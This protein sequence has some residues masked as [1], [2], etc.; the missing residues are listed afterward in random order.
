MKHFPCICCKQS[1]KNNQKALLCT[2]CNEWIHISCAGIPKR[3]Y[4][5]DTEHFVNWQCRKCLFRILPFYTSEN[6]QCKSSITKK[7]SSSK[8]KPDNIDLP[9]KCNITGKGLKFAHLNVVSL[10]K[11][12]EEIKLFLEVNDIDILALNETRLDETVFDSEITIPLYKL[13]RK[14]RNKQGGGVAIYF[15]NSLDVQTIAHESLCHL[16]ANCIKIFMKGSRPILFLNWYRPPNSKADIWDYYEHFLEFADSLN[17]NIVIMGDLNVDILNVNHNVLNHKYLALNSIYSLNQINMTEPTRI[18]HECATLLD[19]MITNDLSN[20]QSHGIVHVGMSDHS[21]SY[22]VWKFTRQ[23]ERSRTTQYRNL[24]KFVKEEFKKDLRSQPWHTVVNCSNLDEAV[25]RWQELLL[26]VVDKHMPIRHKRT[27]K[28]PSPWM[29]AHIF[30]LMKERDKVKKAAWKRKDK[31]LM[32]KYRKL[33]NKVNA[34]VKKYKK[35]YYVNKLQQSERNPNEVWKTLKSLLPNK[36]SDTNIQSGN[37]QHMTNDFNNFF[38]NIGEELLSTIPTLQND[39]WDD[40]LDYF[41]DEKF[42]IHI[43]FESD[44]LAQINRMKNKNSVGLDGISSSILK[45][46]AEEITPS[47]TY[48]INRA[49]L[50]HRVPTQWKKA[51]IIPLH[52][53]GNKDLPNNYRPISLLPVV[54]KILERVVHNQLSIYLQR[55]NLL[56]IEQSGFRPKHSVDCYHSS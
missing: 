44:I 26:E 43:V 40:T 37:E 10:I 41:S 7:S 49:I 34:E 54:S 8:I 23:N 3:V 16:E 51:K 42:D 22:F 36:K 4:D 19:H 15:K 6:H 5:D 45:L 24:S 46:S 38:A 12:F 53:N 13:I 11:N 56:A 30:K 29:N 20:V 52:K 47:L 39:N 31:E 17:T 18:T 55:C 32:E 33:R 14:D 25:D 1:V 50:E 35:L 21:L 27:R 9:P 2:A 48:L 28:T